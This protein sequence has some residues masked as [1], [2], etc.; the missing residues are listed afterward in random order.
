MGTFQFDSDF[1]TGIKFVKFDIEITA[2]APII[3]DL[4]FY[5]GTGCLNIMRIVKLQRIRESDKHAQEQAYRLKRE[6]TRI[7]TR[8]QY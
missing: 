1:S 2:I 4:K 7:A 3:V 5:I 8:H 6:A